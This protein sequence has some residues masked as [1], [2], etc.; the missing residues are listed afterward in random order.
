MDNLLRLVKEHE[1]ERDT[2]C[3]VTEWKKAATSSIPIHSSANSSTSSPA[4]S[5]NTSQ[6]PISHA[7]NSLFMSQLL[8]VLHKTPATVVKMH[9]LGLCSPLK[10]LEIAYAIALFTVSWYFAIFLPCCADVRRMI[11]TNQEETW[12]WPKKMVNMWFKLETNLVVMTD[13]HRK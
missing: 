8:F 1:D 7:P 5:K 13:F 9:D 6:P 4:Q 2:R 11:A 12:T 10:G 3:K